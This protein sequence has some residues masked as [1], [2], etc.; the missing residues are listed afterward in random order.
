MYKTDYFSNNHM[1]RCP[2]CNRTYANDEFAFCLADGT[3]LSAPYDL[4]EDRIGLPSHR[5]EPPETEVLPSHAKLSD[6]EIRD[7]D[8]SKR[9][10]ESRRR[11]D[12]AQ[13]F[14]EVSKNPNTRISES[15]RK[16]FELSGE[17]ADKLDFGSGSQR[18]SFNVKFNHISRKSLFTVFSDGTLQLNFSWLLDE[19][20]APV[21][22][23]FGQELKNLFGRTISNNFRE[24]RIA[25]RPEQWT[26]RLDAFIEVVRTVT[27]S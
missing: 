16:L 21:A 7:A 8:S 9:T 22:E 13:F 3:L 5:S 18:C 27:K 25:V 26:P 6:K 24:R 1:K 20:S 14:Q 10:S 2:T 15:V 12:E 11:C 4:R 17:I 19:K 23:M